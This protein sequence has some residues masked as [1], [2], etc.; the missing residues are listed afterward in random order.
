MK[1]L[2]QKI[3][4]NGRLGEHFYTKKEINIFKKEIT[5][6]KKVIIQLKKNCKN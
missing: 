5:K 6:L 1:I 3:V 4:F 2:K